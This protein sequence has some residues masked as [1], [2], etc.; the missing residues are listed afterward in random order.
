MKTLKNLREA[1][2]KERTV[3]KR[4]YMG[5]KLE[6]IQRYDKFEAYVDG[7]KLDTYD[8][9]KHAMKMIMQFVREVD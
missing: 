1:V 6:I 9:K 4:K 8:T 2:K 7:E 5:F 3:Y